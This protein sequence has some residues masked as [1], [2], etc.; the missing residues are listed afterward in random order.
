[1]RIIT[2]FD[3]TIVDLSQRYYEI[4]QLC[5]G[6]VTQSDPW[7]VLTK[8]EFWAHKRAGMNEIQIGIESKLTLMQ[9]EYYQALRN[10]E[11][12]QL[13][14]LGSDRPIIGAMLTLQ[15]IRKT[16]DIELVLLTLRRRSELDRT[17]EQYDMERFFDTHCQYCLADDYVKQGYIEDKTQLLAKALAEL[18]DDEDTWV[19]GDTEAD[20]VAAETF[21]LKSIAVLSGIRDRHFL[22]QYRS[23]A[24][25]PNFTAGVNMILSGKTTYDPQEEESQ[26]TGEH[27]SRNPNPRDW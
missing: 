21:Q 10:R 18:G 23:N 26:Q 22:E 7:K 16:T 11:V 20:L 14:Y 25:V 6:I 13:K 2:D 9:A 5:L 8:E 1:M 24:I 15:R 12:H 17:L 27:L 3:G 4:Y 19:I